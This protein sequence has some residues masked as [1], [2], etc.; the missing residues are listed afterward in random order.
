MLIQGIF[1]NRNNE[2]RKICIFCSNDLNVVTDKGADNNEVNEEQGVDNV[3]VA[4]DEEDTD[5]KWKME[6]L[7]LNP[8][9]AGV[10][11]GIETVHANSRDDSRNICH[12][13]MI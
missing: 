9:L 7:H 6:G 11:K 1:M 10:T 13:H 5:L 12:M 8:A 3:V 4:V 2:V